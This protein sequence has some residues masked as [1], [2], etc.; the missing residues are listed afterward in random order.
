V[1]STGKE[2]SGMVDYEKLAAQAKAAQDA[3]NFAS[4]SN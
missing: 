1:K 4:R 3:A 2:G